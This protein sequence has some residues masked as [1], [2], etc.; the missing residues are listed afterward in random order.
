MDVL[1]GIIGFEWDAWNTE[2]IKKHNVNPEEAEQTFFDERKV[3][4]EDTKHS[5][6]EDRYILIGKTKR[7]RVLYIVFTLRK[8]RIRVISARDINKKREVN[9][10]EKAA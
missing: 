2:H 1:K 10:Y 4:G 6:G 7:D 8:S 5:N 9:M 3:V